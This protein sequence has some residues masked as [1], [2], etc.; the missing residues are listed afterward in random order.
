MSNRRRRLREADRRTE[1]D[2]LLGEVGDHVAELDATL[3]AFFE[4]HDRLER[5]MR[6]SDDEPTLE[7][8]EDG[9]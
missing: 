7:R 5:P 1:T 9:H 6:A 2:P 8:L 4:N 3:A